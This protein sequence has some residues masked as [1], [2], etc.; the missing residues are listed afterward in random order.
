MRT[1]FMHLYTPHNNATHN[2]METWKTCFII[3]Y[4]V[5]FYITHNFTE[6]FYKINVFFGRK[7]HEYL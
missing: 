2:F 3:R 5:R 7:K 4:K 1:N 6:Y